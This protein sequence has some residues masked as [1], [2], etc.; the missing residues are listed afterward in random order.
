MRI[1]LRFL[2][3][4]VLI[5]LAES[6]C[7]GTDQ[8]HIFMA[9]KSIAGFNLS[10]LHQ[11]QDHQSNWSR[12]PIIEIMLPSKNLSGIVLWKYVGNMSQLSTLDLSSNNLK[13]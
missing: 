13:E 1:L 8:E 12:P 10:W 7:N 6:T 4:L 3:L 9:F 2:V 5:A 11:Q